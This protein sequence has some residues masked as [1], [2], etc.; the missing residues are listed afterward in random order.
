MNVSPV[1]TVKVSQFKAQF[2]GEEGF[3]TPVVVVRSLLEVFGA[4]S[5]IQQPRMCLGL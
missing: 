3:N 4:L 1:A 2:T 5:V